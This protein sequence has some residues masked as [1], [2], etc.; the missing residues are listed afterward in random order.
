MGKG[1]ISRLAID[2]SIQTLITIKN[3]ANRLE[4]H[5]QLKM[6]TIK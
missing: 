6:A 1:K 3:T 4:Q 5:F 2:Y